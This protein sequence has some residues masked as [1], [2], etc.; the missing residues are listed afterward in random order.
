MVLVATLVVCGFLQY[1]CGLQLRAFCGPSSIVVFVYL[2]CSSMV[3]GINLS[4][5]IEQPSPIPQRF[6]DAQVYLR[7][8][9]ND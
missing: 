8:R 1:S 2:L 6:W 7:N 9:M 4:V 3:K 5:S